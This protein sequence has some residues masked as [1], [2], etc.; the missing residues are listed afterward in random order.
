MNFVRDKSEVPDPDMPIYSSFG[1]AWVKLHA[2]FGY[3]VGKA[4]C[5]GS[6][7]VRFDEYFCIVGVASAAPIPPMKGESL[8]TVV[9]SMPII[10]CCEHGVME[11]VSLGAGV[12]GPVMTSIPVEYD[13]KWYI[14]ELDK[15]GKRIKA[16]KRKIPRCVDLPPKKIPK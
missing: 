11:D 2:F 12:R 6:K 8:P 1:A 7:Q 13:T 5:G 10:G 4:I 9:V 15:P 3:Q 14:E 16:I